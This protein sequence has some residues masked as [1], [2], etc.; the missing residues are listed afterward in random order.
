MSIPAALAA[1][2]A[3]YEKTEDITITLI[4]KAA[5]W[6]GQAPWWNVSYLKEVNRDLQMHTVD[7][8]SSLWAEE[9][10]HNLL[11]DLATLTMLAFTGSK[12]LI[13]WME[14]GRERYI[15]HPL[16]GHR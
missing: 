12:V 16:D 8:H 5:V 13:W 14:N 11:V 7:T 6:P 9:L 1:E 2:V 10:V 15:S 3:K 4:W